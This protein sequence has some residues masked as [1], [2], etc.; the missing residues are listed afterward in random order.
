LWGRADFDRVQA[1]AQGQG[2]P[3]SPK[4][5]QQHRGVVST[6]N[7]GNSR[8]N[9]CHAGTWGQAELLPFFAP[10]APMG[11]CNDPE[12]GDAEQQNWTAFFSGFIRITDPGLYNFSVLFDDGYF[13]KLIGA[14]GLTLEIEE[15]FLNPRD[16]EGFADDLQL[17]TGLYAF[18]L[19]AWNRLGAG[20]VDLRWSRGGDEPEWNLVPIENLLPGSSVAEPAVPLLLA[21]AGLASWLA[22]GLTRRNR[23]ATALAA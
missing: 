22:T 12:L 20:V 14:G 23:R 3:G 17:S 8:Y 4:I 16:R 13:F 1:A 10:V 5:E 21:L 15:D 11:T 18:E 6:I 7:Y 2:D 19:G 9:E